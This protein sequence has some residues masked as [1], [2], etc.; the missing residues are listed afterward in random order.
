MALSMHAPPPLLKGVCANPAE[1]RRGTENVAAH[2]T[3]PAVF[4][5]ARRL[6]S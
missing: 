6:G 5:I 1:N 2:R 4:Y 3:G